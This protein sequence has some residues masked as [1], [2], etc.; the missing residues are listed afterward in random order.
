MASDLI[1]L[2][3]MGPYREPKEPAFSYDYSVQRPDWSTPQGVRIK[4]DIESELNYLKS[5]L[6]CSGGSAGQQLRVNQILF[7]AI[8]EQKLAL[9]DADGKLAERRDVMIGPFVKELSHLSDLLNEWMKAEQANLRQLVKDQ[10][11]I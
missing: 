5:L 11:G 1:I 7:R 6:N 9:V 2:N 10:V 8:A 4:V 3:V